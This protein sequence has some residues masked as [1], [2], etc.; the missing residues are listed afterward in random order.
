[1]ALPDTQPANV[2]KECPATLHGSD[3]YDIDPSSPSLPVPTTPE[4][5]RSKIF[6]AS[7]VYDKHPRKYDTFDMD[8]K[9]STPETATRSNFPPRLLRRRA[10]ISEVLPLSWDNS[11]TNNEPAIPSRLTSRRSS[12]GLLK[13][14]PNFGVD[15]SATSQLSQKA[16]QSAEAMKKDL[17]LNQKKLLRRVTEGDLYAPAKTI[18]ES[19]VLGGLPQSTAFAPSGVSDRS[20]DVS[21]TVMKPKARLL[22]G[23]TDSALLGPKTGSDQHTQGNLF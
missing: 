15:S 5:I 21:E 4:A 23:S 7:Q 18:P 9:A 8:K 17:K 6:D 3:R 2:P 19:R 13:I 1:M 12:D 22:R 11:N 14:P 20:T 10:T 16:D